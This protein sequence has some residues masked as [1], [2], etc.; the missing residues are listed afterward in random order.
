MC[1]AF[2]K[3][4][5]NISLYTNIHVS[6]AELKKNYGI[7]KKFKIENIYYTNITKPIDIFI[8]SLHI[9]FKIFF[10]SN[11]IYYT[12][13]PFIL[14]ILLILKKNVI[15]EIHNRLDNYSK[16][17][18]NIISKFK[19]LKH[20]KIILIVFIT[21]NLKNYYIDK[22]SELSKNIILPDCFDKKNNK[23]V[24][25]RI[26]K[27]KSVGYFGS[28]K[29]GKGI[30]MIK[31]ISVFFPS[32]TFNIFGGTSSEI[33]K[34]WKFLPNLKFHGNLEHSKVSKQMNN[35]DILI[36]PYS[37]KVFGDGNQDLSMWMSPLKLFEYI[38]ANKPIISSDL[39]VLREIVD[40]KNV[41][42]AKPDSLNSW[43]KTINYVERN[44]NLISNKLLL[45]KIKFAQFSWENRAKKILYHLQ[46]VWI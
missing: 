4:K 1:E 8:F 20:K 11:N 15:L 7:K 26:K 21:N 19:L 23:L 38:N 10:Q 6:E 27:I 40:E 29:K 9:F 36:M 41:F 31:K 44:T 46:N 17:L 18:D 43:I 12:R 28:F 42:F 5:I 33:K 24:M 2:S 16:F 45:N 35:Q 34:N 25:N 3:N 39:K 30:E 32:L 22:Y 14:L 37:M 13:D